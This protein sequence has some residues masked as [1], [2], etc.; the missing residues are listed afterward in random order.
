MK[1]SI[2]TLLSIVIFSCSSN[3]KDEYKNDQSFYEN[4]S[5]KDYELFNLANDY[6][7]NNQLDLA[8]IELDKLEVIY[9]SSPFANKSMLVFS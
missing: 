9:P 3:D 5:L 6:I 1:K 8:L 7:I 2:L 4:N